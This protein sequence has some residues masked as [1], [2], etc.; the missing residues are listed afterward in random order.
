MKEIIP[1][2]ISIQNMIEGLK[3]GHYAIPVFQRDFVWDINN[4]KS[5]W[6]SIYRHYPIGS[7]LIWETEEKL[8]RH[9]KILDI[10]LKST[11]R[12]TFNYILD[13]QQRITSLISSIMG[14]KLK[15]KT[16]TIYLDLKKAFENSK[17]NSIL[18]DSLFIDEKELEG[19]P[20]T[21]RDFFVPV[22]KL[23]K[24]DTFYYK[25]LIKRGEEILADFYHD[26]SEVMTNNYKLSIIRLNK[27]PL[28]EIPEIFTRVNQKGKKLSLMEL[29]IAKTFKQDEFYLPDYLD[30]L[31]EVLEKEN[32]SGV[33]LV[34]F[35]RA[36]STNNIQSCK[37]K[38]LLSLGHNKII[39]LWQETTESF[40]QAIRFLKNELNLQNPEIIP[41][42]PMLISLS[43]FFFK[44]K[45]KILKPEVKEMVKKWFWINSFTGNYQGATLEKIHKDCLWFDKILNEEKSLNVRFTQRIDKQDIIDQELSLSSAFCK[46]IL[47]LFANLHPIDFGNHYA[48]NINE[49][50]IKSRK[51]E[52]HHIFPKKSEVGQKNKENILSIVNVCFITKI[53]N[54]KILNKNPSLYLKDCKQTNNFLE[55]DIKTHIIPLELLNKDNFPEFLEER[56]EMIKKEIYRLCGVVNPIEEELENNPNKV[57]D[58][59][60]KKI[61]ELINEVLLESSEDYW[62]K[63]I[64]QDIVN[65]VKIKIDQELKIKPFRKE[66]LK[67]PSKKMEF[68]DIMDYY[69]IISSNFS[70][71]RDIFGSEEEL[72]SN[73]LNLKNLRNPLKHN[74]VLDEIDNLKGKASLLWLD[75]CLDVQEEVMD[76][77][78]E[79][80]EEENLMSIF[81]EFK[82]QIM[83]FGKDIDFIKN[84]YY[85]AFKRS[86]NFVSIKIQKNKIKLYFRVSPEDLQDPLKIVRDV[87]EIGHHGTGNY[88]ISFAS[89]EDIPYIIQIIKIAYESDINQKEDYDLNHHLSKVKDPLTE[90]RIKEIFLSV[91]SL[92]K[93]VIE[94]YSKNHI[95]FRK[96]YDFCLIYCQ[97]DQ[98]WID[99]KLPRESIKDKELDVRPHKD[100]VWTHI[101][102]NNQF[103]LKL[104]D[105]YIKMAYEE[106]K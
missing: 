83:S 22:A 18:E 16:L 55:E 72:R 93:D 42:P 17:N 26:I 50:F 19:E 33:D 65:S 24:F 98:F 104:L 45:N 80:G 28:E 20:L 105:P 59:Y 69:K 35:L 100:E 103:N 39:A 63:V 76:E 10:E 4:I 27:I 36:I 102:I 34:L 78:L 97:T 53:T 51:E 41:Y 43:Y 46:S 14:A 54:Q 70:L 37:E 48:I 61:R 84:K 12:G 5:L 44:L 47:C 75:K 60:E 79:K 29:M 68:L 8:P 38:E 31:E 49:F 92:G 94:H 87:A 25:L 9:R 32:Y 74:R 52:L 6:D 2:A 62:D 58:Y 40:L 23:I 66:D 95:K 56:A 89:K 106:N 64:P 88:E 96:T 30:K 77:G 7:F 71:F 90:K 73:F 81:E 91:K 3:D 11:E 67:D 99:L 86:N 85:W 57:V 21:A 82:K 15:N 13:G 101:R 1:E